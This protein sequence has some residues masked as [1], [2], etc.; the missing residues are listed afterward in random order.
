MTAEDRLSR[1]RQRMLEAELPALLVSQPES[2]R[3]LSGYT[4]KDVPPRESAGYLLI[5]EDRQF[6]L[7]DPRTE[8]QAV[9]Q[10]SAFEVRIYRAG[11]PLPDIV[12]KL[13]LESRIDKIGFDAGHLSFGAW[14]EL[15]D[16]LDDIAALVPAPA[17]VDRLRMVKDADEIEALRASILPDS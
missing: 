11:S 4:A 13:A 17:L 8:G 7:T 12:K 9:A 1:L 5:T 3:Y 14:R 16:G 10:A 2:R 15:S 6:L